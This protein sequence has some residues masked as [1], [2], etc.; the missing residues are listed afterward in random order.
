MEVNWTS[1]I[2]YK[3]ILFYGWSCDT[4]SFS[5]NWKSRFL[6]TVGCSVYFQS[7]KCYCSWSVC[8][9]AFHCLVINEM[10]TSSRP[11]LCEAVKQVKHFSHIF[12]CWCIYL[13]L[14]Y[15]IKWTQ[16]LRINAPN[17][18]QWDLLEKNYIFYNLSNIYI[19]KKRIQTSLHY[20]VWDKWTVPLVLNFPL[21]L[22]IVV[23]YIAETFK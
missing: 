22:K 6:S 14:L 12:E 20:F 16:K 8:S 18:S 15:S 2:Y 4:A 17:G 7:Q 9:V 10:S 13:E 21:K 5:S 1:V 23:L 19:P 11:V 3:M